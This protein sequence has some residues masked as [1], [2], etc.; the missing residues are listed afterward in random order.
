MD[1]SIIL[2]NGV[3]YD[4]KIHSN[5]FLKKHFNII[6]NKI[7][8]ADLKQEILNESKQQLR[9]CEFKPKP[10]VNLESCDLTNLVINKAN[11]KTANLRNSNL[12]NTKINDTI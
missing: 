1:K 2:P 5:E 3:T 12:S 10:G 8:L 4:K 7:D 6:I 9:K 11:L